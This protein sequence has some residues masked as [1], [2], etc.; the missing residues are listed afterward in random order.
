MLKQTSNKKNSKSKSAAM[1]I[2]LMKEDDMDENLDMEF[3]IQFNK[4]NCWGLHE[5]LIRG[6]NQKLTFMNSI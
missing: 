2:D 6:Q 4:N 1:P 5:L 3:I